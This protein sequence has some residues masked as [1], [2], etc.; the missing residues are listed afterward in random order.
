MNN[1]NIHSDQHQVSLSIVGEKT[2]PLETVRNGANFVTKLLI[3][4][5]KADPLNDNYDCP[6]PDSILAQG[7]IEELNDACEGEQHGHV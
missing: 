4:D 2:Y 3:H 7:I 1:C 5:V 6:A